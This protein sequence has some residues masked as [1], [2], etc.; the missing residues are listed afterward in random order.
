M[1]GIAATAIFNFLDSVGSVVVFL[2]IYAAYEIPVLIG[3]WRASSKY[4]GLKLWGVLA[5]IATT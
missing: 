5:K 2:A 4:E 3:I 1:V